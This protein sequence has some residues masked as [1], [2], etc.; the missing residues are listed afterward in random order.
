MTTDLLP[1]LDGGGESDADTED[2][3]DFGDSDVEDE[4]QLAADWE[5]QEDEGETDDEF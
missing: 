4:Q 5:I 2:E 1:F 3:S